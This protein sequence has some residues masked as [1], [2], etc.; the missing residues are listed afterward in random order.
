MERINRIVLVKAF[1][2]A[3]L[4]MALLNAAIAKV[5]EP[6]SRR[7]EWVE[8][9][10]Q[11]LERGDLSKAETLLKRLET[12]DPGLPYSQLLA[13]LLAYKKGRAQDSLAA[14]AA[15]PSSER[16][17]DYY[18]YY[19]FALFDSAS[20]STSLIN[21][22]LTQALSLPGQPAT[23]FMANAEKFLDTKQ[24]DKLAALFCRK[25]AMYPE[26]KSPHCRQKVTLLM[27]PL[28]DLVFG[29]EAYAG[30][31]EGFASFL[32]RDIIQ[33]APLRKAFHAMTQFIS[34]TRKKSASVE[35]CL[36]PISQPYLAGGNH[37]VAIARTPLVSVIDHV[38]LHVT[39]GNQ[40][41]I[42][43]TNSGGDSRGGFNKA[44]S[45]RKAA[46]CQPLWIPKEFSDVEFAA[47]LTKGA[48]YLK[49]KYRFNYN[50]AWNNC[51]SYAMML[52]QCLGASVGYTPNLAIF[53]RWRSQ[54]AWTPNDI[55]AQS[56]PTFSDF[57]ANSSSATEEAMR[58]GPAAVSGEVVC[59]DLQQY[60]GYGG[61]SAPSNLA[62]ELASNSVRAPAHA[63]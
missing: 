45:E 22:T 6:V 26:I 47:M 3:F 31:G 9:A 42:W 19:F 8:D 18:A 44:F 63:L 11:A 52:T 25:S 54:G 21:E 10:G 5:V 48:S 20:P 1:F 38:F 36:E 29:R 32:S 16:D 17:A 58:G 33:M 24:D 34:G 35:M 39:A 27:R 30:L 37:D 13:A 41:A 55:A 4:T 50:F 61:G 2:A 7:M 23:A 60:V 62:P 49:E 59:R 46:S 14:F 51:G 28:L 57:L 53:S 12:S 56:A 40:D 15:V 43:E